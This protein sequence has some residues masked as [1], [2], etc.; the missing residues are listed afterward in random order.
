M[1]IQKK[2]TGYQGRALG[3]RKPKI[4]R[5][6]TVHTA[7]RFNRNQNELVRESERER[8]RERE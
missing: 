3:G 4:K 1:S 2:K 6:Q 7:H 8:E 5:N